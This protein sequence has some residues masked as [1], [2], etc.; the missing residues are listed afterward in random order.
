MYAW[1]TLTAPKTPA[2]GDSATVAVGAITLS[3]TV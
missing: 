1:W 3:Y 2:N